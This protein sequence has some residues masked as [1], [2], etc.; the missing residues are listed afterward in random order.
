LAEAWLFLLGYTTAAA[1]QILPNGAA[2]IF[3]SVFYWIELQ[4][5]TWELNCSFPETVDGICSKTISK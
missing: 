3:R 1:I 4:V 5:L 2:G